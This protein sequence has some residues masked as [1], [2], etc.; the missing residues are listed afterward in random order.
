[1]SVVVLDEAHLLPPEFL[2]PIL[3]ALNLL[4]QYYGVTMVLCTAT[5]P[6]LATREYFDPHRNLRGLD[7]VREIIADPDALYR[8][9]KRVEVRL[10]QDWTTPVPW[11]ELA[12]RL[13]GHDSVL[14]IVNTRRHA[15]ELHGLMPQGTLH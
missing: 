1:D 12:A 13:S 10:P 11:P 7:S 15:R 2:Q 4:A 3:D 14:A 5:Q 6:A 9:L 8:Q